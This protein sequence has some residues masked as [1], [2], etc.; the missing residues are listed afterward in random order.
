VSMPI[1]CLHCGHTA[2]TEK[3]VYVGSAVRCPK[4]KRAF[5]VTDESIDRGREFVSQERALPVPDTGSDAGKAV[6]TRNVDDEDA[7][8]DGHLTQGDE[9]RHPDTMEG[10]F[11]VLPV[12]PWFYG[13]LWSSGQALRFV[14]DGGALLFTLWCFLAFMDFR[15]KATSVANIG[16]VLAG[17]VSALFVVGLVW[18]ILRLVAAGV[19]LMVDVARN[20]RSTSLATEHS[21]FE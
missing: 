7:R 5:D 19:L 14:A 3:Q 17:L 16:I 11:M 18:F 15:G 12:E 1:T 4:C 10:V 13:S 9:A 6:S 8:T 21:H 20:I 2:H